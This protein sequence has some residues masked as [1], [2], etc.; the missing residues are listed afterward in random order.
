[1]VCRLGNPNYAFMT[2]KIKNSLTCLV[3]Y[4]RFIPYQEGARV[5]FLM[6]Q[7]NQL[8]VQGLVF[9]LINLFLFFFD[10]SI[11]LIETHYFKTS[12]GLSSNKN[13]IIKMY[14][15]YMFGCK[16]TKRIQTYEITFNLFKIANSRHNIY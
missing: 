4:I 6:F 5:N 15:T 12:N 7:V 1:M 13:Y 3:R 11:Y 10:F 16:R 8:V 9:V 2:D 14:G